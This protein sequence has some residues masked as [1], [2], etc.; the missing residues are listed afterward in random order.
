MR[1]PHPPAAHAWLWEYFEELS[2]PGPFTGWAFEW[3]VV[4]FSE[5]DPDHRDDVETDDESKPAAAKLAQFF[6]PG[7]FLPSPVAPGC[8]GCSVRCCRPSR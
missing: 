6:G 7:C 4:C 8:T 5:P 2:G 3:R 1:A